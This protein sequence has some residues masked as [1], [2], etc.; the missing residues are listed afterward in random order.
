[1][2]QMELGTLDSLKTKSNLLTLAKEILFASWISYGHL[3][4]GGVPKDP[5]KRKFDFFS[6]Q[7]S[8]KGWV[9]E[10]DGAAITDSQLRQS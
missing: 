2:N 8:Q 1:V 10:C 5:E 7:I 6:L 9:C 4:F 3:Q